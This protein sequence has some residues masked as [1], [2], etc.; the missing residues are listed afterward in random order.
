M[1]LD[2]C[3]VCPAYVTALADVSAPLLLYPPRVSSSVTSIGEA[4]KSLLPGVDV[5]MTADAASSH[6]YLVARKLA[7]HSI[8]TPILQVFAYPFGLVG[9]LIALLSLPM[10][11][12][13]DTKNS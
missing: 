2:S 4:I 12:S 5:K 8:T 11:L 6:K 10:A 9:I 7:T 13:A 3:N 1:R